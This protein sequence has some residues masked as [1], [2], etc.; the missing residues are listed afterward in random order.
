[1]KELDLNH[2]IRLL[3]SSE[4][5]LRELKALYEAFGKDEENRHVYARH[6]N[7]LLIQYMQKEM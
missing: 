3:E 5:M 6:M 4:L 1:M 7:R 2:I